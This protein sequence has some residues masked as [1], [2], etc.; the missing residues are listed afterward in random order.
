VAPPRGGWRA[1]GGAMSPGVRSPPWV[2]L[3]G[4]VP[5]DGCA[6]VRARL[7]VGLGEG[8]GGFREKT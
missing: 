3:G 7:W 4:P 8:E 2:D 6:G 5:P 1:E